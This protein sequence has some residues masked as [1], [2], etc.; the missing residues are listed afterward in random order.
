VLITIVR[1]ENEKTLKRI[2]LF[3]TDGDNVFLESYVEEYLSIS[4][5]QY[6]SIFEKYYNH[7]PALSRMK[8][9]DIKTPQDVR[10]EIIKTVI[11]L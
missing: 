9:E 10:E 2:W 11:N 4:S 5:H 1:Y 8:K 6:K 3:N 7:D